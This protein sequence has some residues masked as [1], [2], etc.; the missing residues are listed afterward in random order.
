MATGGHIGIQTGKKIGKKTLFQE[1][2]LPQKLSYANN[3]GFSVW[4]QILVWT[5]CIICNGQQRERDGFIIPL[6]K[7]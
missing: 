5:T 7:M 1:L 2:V 3:K 6:L 4:Y